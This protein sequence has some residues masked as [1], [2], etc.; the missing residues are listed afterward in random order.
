MRGSEASVARPGRR[1]VR[2]SLLQGC[3]F[4]ASAPRGGSAQGSPRHSAAG[5]SVP[6]SLA[7]TCGAPGCGGAPRGRG[8]GTR[9]WHR[10]QV[11]ARR[12]QVPQSEQGS[13]CK[14]KSSFFNQGTS[15]TAGMRPQA[16]VGGR[17]GQASA[18]LPSAHPSRF[19]TCNRQARTRAGN[20]TQAAAEPPGHEPRPLWGPSCNPRPSE[21]VGVGTQPGP[22]LSR[23]VL[24]RP[25]PLRPPAP[26]LP[27]APGW[28][29][30]SQ[31]QAQGPA[32][33]APTALG[34]APASLLV[35][36]QSRL[37]EEVCRHGTKASG[38]RG[39]GKATR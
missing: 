18:I 36:P 34:A 20:T 33:R 25:L 38:A 22:A 26:D 28:H 5:C 14:A 6:G 2:S 29:R 15:K 37:P 3:G 16:N 23:R 7:L 30:C 27:A 12:R 24:R 21:R 17:S 11:T 8:S 4:K 1:A 13:L 31:T 32:A 39:E 9:P 10:G 35:P 19:R